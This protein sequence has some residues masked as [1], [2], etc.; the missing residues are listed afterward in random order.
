M[1]KYKK[2]FEDDNYLVINK[3][4]GLLV[5]GAPHI[6]EP[7]LVDQL[8]KKY[9]KIAKVGDDPNRPGIVHRLDK[10]AS[11]LMVIAKTQQSFNDLKE[12]FQ[13][14]TI[15]KYY[16][17]LVYGKIERDEGEINFPIE[18]SAKG[19]RM[20]AK[21]STVKGEKNEAG[22]NAFTEFTVTKRYINY[23][24]IKVKI[25]TGR[26]HQVRVHMSAYGN[27][28]V[29]DDLYGTKKTKEKNTR[30]RKKQEKL[31]LERIFLVANELEF[32]DLKGKKKNFKINLPENLEK[33]LEIVK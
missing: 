8:L 12:Q 7:T 28:V 27:P 31:N 25:K 13:K 30:L 11:G 1:I 24:L 20:A 3:P 15:S 32:A 9:P 4:A 29:G 26:T 33:L 23:T 16:T 18:R 2:I 19:H 6:K 10:L 21:P 22:R 5:H 14:R 17:A